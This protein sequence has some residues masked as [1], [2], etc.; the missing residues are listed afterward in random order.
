MDVG[1]G[2]EARI[3]DAPRRLYLVYGASKMS[4]ND[5]AEEAGVSR[6][7]V[8]KYYE[9]RKELLRRLADDGTSTMI[10]HLDQAMANYTTLE[11]QVACTARLMRDWTLQRR[12]I[13]GR[14]H[15]TFLALGFTRD[16]GPI[17]NAL[18]ELMRG[19]IRLAKA[20]GEVRR[21][22]NLDHSSEWTARM[23][24]SLMAVPAQTFDFEDPAEFEKFVRSF[25]V[26]GLD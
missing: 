22:I 1:G 18:A 2:M 4:L 25:M 17:L 15:Q 8:Y 20:R 3:L 21:G 14:T 7:S 26:K 13:G 19:Y 6:G 5:V 23:L 10:E 12:G 9:N 11:D 16:A 24:L